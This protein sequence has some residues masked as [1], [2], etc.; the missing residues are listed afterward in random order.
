MKDVKGIGYEVRLQANI[1]EVRD[2]VGEALAGQGFGI[3]T[4]IDVQATLKEKLGMESGA[5]LIL[6]VCNPQLAHQAL[7]HD[8]D[9]GLLLPCT[10]T[11]RADESETLVAW[12]RPQMALELVGAAG[13]AEIASEAERRLNLALSPLDTSET[14]T[15]GSEPDDEDARATP[16]AESL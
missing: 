14:T 15:P 8:P 9:V 10:V 6:G 5:Y 12:L 11:L 2:R 7:E 16:G 4:E 1:A 3:L 13:L